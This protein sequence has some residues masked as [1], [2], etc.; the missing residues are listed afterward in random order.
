MTE[1]QMQDCEKAAHVRCEEPGR[2][3]IDRTQKEDSISPAAEKTQHRSYRNTA[4]V[5][6]SSRVAPTQAQQSRPW[7][8]RM[9]VWIDD[10][11]DDADRPRVIIGYA[12]KNDSKVRSS[13]CH[14][15]S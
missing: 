1:L 13:S 10:D 3:T 12:V 2:P 14:R 7:W 5:Q 15:F 9:C 4:K 11:D 6:K 8:K